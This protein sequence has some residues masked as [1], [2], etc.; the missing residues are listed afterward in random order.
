MMQELLV[1][2]S[3]ICVQPTGHI[4]A[5]NATEFQTRL[6]AA[7]VQSSQQ[8][9]VV[10]LSEVESLDSAGLMVLISARNLA[11]KSSVDFHLCGV[12]PTLK[13]IFEVTQLDRVFQIH[14]DR[15]IV[16]SM[17]AA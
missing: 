17:L 14:A 2:P 6:E 9:L 7:V 11:Q 10:D 4:N 1:K 12:S 15:A 3:M 5:A 8:S 13:I 16:E